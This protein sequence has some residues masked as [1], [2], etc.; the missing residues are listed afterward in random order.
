MAKNPGKTDQEELLNE[1][2]DLL[3]RN[4]RLEDR[5]STMKRQLELLHDRQ[6]TLS[7]RDEI[8]NANILACRRAVAAHIRTLQDLLDGAHVRQVKGGTPR[9]IGVLSFTFFEDGSMNRM[10]HG[11]LATRSEYVELTKY[12]ATLGYASRTD[13]GAEPAGRGYV[14]QD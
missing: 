9:L 1:N 14:E 13:D 6:H 5:I 7:E 3:Q 10:R 4:A 12:A 2:L 8:A 11:L